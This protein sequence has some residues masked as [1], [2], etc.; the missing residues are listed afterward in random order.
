MNKRPKMSKKIGL[1]EEKITGAA[2]VSEKT[3]QK[4]KKT[5]P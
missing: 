2:K 1:F 4:P 3:S 5:A